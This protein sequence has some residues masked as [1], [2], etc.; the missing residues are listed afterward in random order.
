MD[1]LCATEKNSTPGLMTQG[2]DEA[3]ESVRQEKERELRKLVAEGKL[4]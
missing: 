3:W 4:Q 1:W 2:A